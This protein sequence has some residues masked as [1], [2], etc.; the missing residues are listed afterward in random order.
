MLSDYSALFV[1]VT[2]LG[3]LNGLKFSTIF[4]VIVKDFLY[5]SSE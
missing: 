4:I 5:D 1:R 2:V 3:M